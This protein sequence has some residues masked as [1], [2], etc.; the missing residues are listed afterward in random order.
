[1]EVG[2]PIKEVEAATTVAPVR[3]RTVHQGGTPPNSNNRPKRVNSYELGPVLPCSHV[4]ASVV[5]EG[6]VRSCRATF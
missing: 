3:F 4:G 6:A 1:M 2:A 5:A